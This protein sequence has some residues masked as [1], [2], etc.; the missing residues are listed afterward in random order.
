M[1]W[2]AV[3]VFALAFSIF[4]GV[5]TYNLGASDARHKIRRA[6]TAKEQKANEEILLMDR[7]KDDLR[8]EFWKRSQE[9][10]SEMKVLVAKVESRL[11]H[12]EKQIAPNRRKRNARS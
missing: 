2:I 7:L 4:L 10:T 3:C 8:A 6:D 1:E 12:I 5:S 9:W 11:S